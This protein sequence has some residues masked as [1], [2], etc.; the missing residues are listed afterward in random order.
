MPEGDK[1]SGE[2]A[3]AGGG[4]NP[5]EGLTVTGLEADLAYF[6]ARLEL[7]GKPRTL[8]QQA[9]YITFRILN[10]SMARM[11]NRLKGKGRKAV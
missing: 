9:Q 5:W 7:I 6:E 11:L 2:T 3:K 1:L 8:N 4:K 10:Q